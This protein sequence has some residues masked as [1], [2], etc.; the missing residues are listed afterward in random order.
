[1]S[2]R[3]DG[4]SRRNGTSCERR[5][6]LSKLFVIIGGAV[7]IA[8]FAA[9]IGP[10][11]VD[12]NDYKTTFEAEAEKIVGRP[13]KVVGSASATL[14]PSPSL[15]FEQV[16]VGDV[17]GEPMMTVDRFAVT[18]ELMPLLQ[19]EF[20]ITTMRLDRPYM[21]VVVN[22]D[23]R[24]D[25]Q[26]RSEASNALDP[27]KIVL[28]NL[29]IA[30]GH[31]TYSDRVGETDLT[32]EGI[33]AV[34]EARSLLGPWRIEGSYLEEGV[35]VPFR[36]ATGRRLDDGTI[37]VKTDLS[38][39]GWP[40][41][42]TADGVLGS[43]DDGLYYDGTY[44]ITEIVTATGAEDVSDSGGDIAGWRSEGKFLLTRHQLAITQ[45]VLSEGPPERPYSVAGSLTVSLGTAP[46]FEAHASARQINLDRSL[47]RGP[48]EPVEV[49]VATE[50]L[51]GWL[52]DSFVPPIPGSVFFNVPGIV[53]GGAV[54][55]N[56][57]FEARPTIGGWR[58]ASFNANLPGR[59]TIEARGVLATDFEVGFAGDVRLVVNQPALF[60]NWW[61][62]QS[63]DGAG[64]LL[65]PFE[66]EG[67]VELGPQQFAFEDI[68]ALFGNAAVSGRF[69]WSDS[70]ARQ[71]RRILETDLTADNIDV[72]QLRAFAELLAGRNL[73]NTNILADSYDIKLAA[74][75]F[76]FEDVSVRDLAVDV[77]FAEDTLTVNEL[78][79]G[80]LGGASLHV[81]EGRIESLRGQPRGHLDAQL[82][83][84]TLT[85][86]TRVLERTMPGHALSR[87]LR[88]AEQSLT[89]A[90]LT[91]S[92]EAP[93]DEGDA[94]VRVSLSGVAAST[95]VSAAVDMSV[96]GGD[97]R[98]GNA[99]IEIVIDS[100]DSTEL[101]RQMG[102][103]V[104]GEGNSGGAHFQIDAGGVPAD[105]LTARF[106]GEFA[107]VGLRSEGRLT[108]AADMPLAYDGSL[109]AA[110]DDI[111]PLMIMIGLDIPVAA[112]ANA[113]RVDG[114]VAIVDQTAEFRLNNSRVADRLINGRLSLAKGGDDSWSIGG[115]LQVD[116]IDL[117]WLTALGLGF[118]L[119]PTDDPAAPWS[120]APFADQG[121]GQASGRIVVAADELVLAEGVNASSAS[122]TIDMQPNRLS[123]D[124]AG[125]RGAGGTLDGGLSIH[126][127][128]GNAR[129]AGRFDLKGAALESLI[130][131]RGGRSVAT[132]AV[133]L[134]A[135][136]E[137]AGR[138]PAAL[139]SS[140][141][142]GGAIT[143]SGGEARYMNPQAARLLIR[144]S[145]LGQEFTENELRD[146]F[147]EQIDGGSFTFDNAE[148]AFAI[149]AG[150][151]RLKSLAVGGDD[152]RVTGDAVIDLPSLS[153][154]SDWTVTFDPGDNRVE[155]ATP[156]VGIVF[157]GPLQS[158]ARIVD[159]LQFGSYL[160]IRQE[161]RLLELLSEAEADRLEAE[162]LNRERRKLREDADRRAR[163]AAEAEA[164]RIAEE[165]EQR[166]LAAEAA[167]RR[168]ADEAARIAD[169]AELQ[170]SAAAVAVQELADA[171][172]ARDAAAEE[173]GRM[174]GE[175]DRQ[176][177]VFEEAVAQAD[178]ATADRLEADEAHSKAVDAQ[179]A[180]EAV[181][182]EAENNAANAA[183]EHASAEVA[184]RAAFGARDV[185]RDAA[186]DSASA[187]AEA[188]RQTGTA[189]DA[190]AA[191]QADIAALTT[192]EQDAAERLANAQRQE[193]AAL[194]A[195][196]AAADQLAALTTAEAAAR[197]AAKDADAAAREAEQRREA[198]GAAIE[199]AQAEVELRA[200]AK[201]DADRTAADAIRKLLI[202]DQAVAAA[203]GTTPEI[204]QGSGVATASDPVAELT[205][206]TDVD[207]TRRAADEAGRA[208]VNAQTI[209]AE[210]EEALANATAEAE[211]LRVVAEEAA[212]DVA[213][214]A[215]AQNAG[216]ERVAVAEAN[217]QASS[218]AAREAKQL[219]AAATGARA[220]GEGEVA[221]LA[222][223]AARLVSIAADAATVAGND[224]AAVVAAEAEAD[225]LAEEAKRLESIADEA[226]QTVVDEEAVLA[227]LTD[228][229]ARLAEEA[230]RQNSAAEAAVGSAA[231]AES[232][233]RAAERRAEEQ[234]AEAE[235]R[236]ELVENAA[237]RVEE[238]EAAQRVTEEQA[239]RLAA[240]AEQQK[241]AAEEATREAL[242]VSVPR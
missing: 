26:T 150:V 1:M 76:Q 18:I 224:Q 5:H 98:Q 110:S 173:V 223:E 218:E 13:V 52:V 159:V 35:A 240:R 175:V 185:L 217:A 200:I 234:M 41:A 203:P 91:A 74:G 112:L 117:G 127:V 126:N 7:V 194:E 165:A 77:G 198:A 161:E 115:N 63:Q 235:R 27:E 130:W 11:F 32:F 101:S 3:H 6:R 61:R 237:R 67:R 81:T 187:Q 131:A 65:A 212:R 199:S 12:W 78:S 84:D 62:G 136:F 73:A 195:A 162:R 171:Q 100:P 31:I 102:L 147:A 188:D 226:K 49:A 196:R 138:S 180:Q 211:R 221:R 163:K 230:A 4:R 121:Y 69:S 142:G 50:S 96:E 23:G 97:W 92:I 227:T 189:E 22:D 157:R 79:V 53:V 58:L 149:A 154:D 207:D 219:A 119:Q 14:L 225:R 241:L 105:G 202:A 8:L 55:Q 238:A 24:L 114:E 99:A 87:W 21:R 229:A 145:D 107:G 216:K 140:L 20:R 106:A 186:A 83:A 125:S 146:A 166:R 236:R 33:N 124:V 206:R 28:E 48:A 191:A 135:E 94:D 30:D 183:R 134:S 120:R 64:R 122:L 104:S 113:T 46:R 174:I 177:L 201:D 153:I 95:T 151:V 37:R 208:L 93:P 133:D 228:E 19:G 167:A 143:I 164:A 232:A 170:R 158:P 132:G 139:A 88:T 54:I 141:T 108:I 25:W 109:A 220:A 40:V 10:R 204:D 214:A 148:G 231:E 45:A 156:Q 129:L 71:H 197:E 111:E 209:Q 38:P 66:I 215:A 205:L 233:Y 178:K 82:E 47:G 17:E 51:V 42:L 80:D 210:A 29:E 103:A 192:A 176:R 39:A 72:T 36:F 68:D 116:A 179:I 168:A 118:A 86:L 15:T 75:L 222:G 160:N 190:A 144:A 85:G 193:R 239:E 60:A 181:V 184:V 137:A 213:D 2:C 16:A 56:V 89:P 34:V 123:V 128:G 182:A 43:G 59:T 155:G 169:E 172:S 70:T 57:A 90:F 44:N 9:L 242:E 152:M